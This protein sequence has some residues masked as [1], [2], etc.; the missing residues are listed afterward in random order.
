MLKRRQLL[1][2]PMAAI[3]LPGATAAFAQTFPARPVKMVIPF[4]AGGGTDV[5][6]RM[7]AKR[8][9]ERSGQPFVVENPTGAGGNIGAA[10]VAR[11]APDGHTLLM[12]FV[13]TQA[14]NPSLYKKLAWSPSD[15]EPVAQVG[16]YPYLVLASASLPVNSIKELIEYAKANPGKVNYGSPGIGSGA[17]LLGSLLSAR[18]GAP[19]THVPYRGS[20]P[21]VQDL[22][23]GTVQIAFDT[24][25]TGQ[26]FVKAGRLKVLGTTSDQ[27]FDFLPEVPTLSQ[28]GLKGMEARGWF[29]LFTTAGVPEPTLRIIKKT[30]TEI[31][32]SKEFQQE[33][34]AVGAMPPVPEAVQ[35]FKGYVDSEIKRWA[36]VVRVSGATAD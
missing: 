24:W 4:S 26:Q 23:A 3:A 25:L 7:I 15:L 11:A 9:S 32:H 34:A 22:L 8:W 35:D 2:W 31:I 21:M 12:S 13:G 17:H 30:A 19:M 16:S 6:G 14:I 1:K 29:G 18:T 33:A 10:Q 28:Q 20:A 27:R 36:E 5:L